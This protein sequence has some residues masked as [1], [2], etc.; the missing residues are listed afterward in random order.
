MGVARILSG[1][2]SESIILCMMLL[3]ISA[4]GGKSSTDSDQNLTPTKA[5]TH[6]S[7]IYTPFKVYTT[8]YTPFKVYTTVYVPFARYTTVYST[9]PN[10]RPVAVAGL[11]QRVNLFEK[12]LLDGTGS[13]DPDGDI[14]GYKWTMVSRPQ[15]SNSSLNLDISSTPNFT[16]DAAGDYVLQ[17]VT[18]DGR[19][20]SI[21]STLTVTASSNVATANITDPTGIVTI[22]SATFD[23]WYQTSSS[24]MVIIRMGAI[25]ND[26]SPHSFDVTYS[27]LDING[28]TVYSS[29]LSG[30]APE[31]FQTSANIPSA[32]YSKINKWVLSNMTKY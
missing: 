21:P 15:G 3:A 28:A 9:I 1:K 5:F 13:S 2:I 10:N 7:T 31:V 29:H 25:T 8:I 14:I 18:N 19:A 23:Y 22:T 11:S 27:A 26:G 32:D 30:P 16:P 20:Y 4:C 12:V 17:L 6:Y 24:V